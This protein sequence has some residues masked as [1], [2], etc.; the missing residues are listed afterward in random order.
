MA[1][2]ATLA[3]R[4]TTQ[5]LLGNLGSLRQHRP[6]GGSHGLPLPY[7]TSG[8]MP[9]P[10]LALQGEERRI[11]P[12]G[13]Q[14]GEAGW[15]VQ[16]Q[17]R[18]VGSSP[19]PVLTESLPMDSVTTVQVVTD[20]LGGFDTDTL[21]N[22]TAEIARLRESLA[23]AEERRRLEAVLFEERARRVEAEL[24]HCRAEGVLFS[25]LCEERDSLVGTLRAELMEA[26]GERDA[27]QAELAEA[28]FELDRRFSAAAGGHA[29]YHSRALRQSSGPPPSSLPERGMLETSGP[30]RLGS[31]PDRLGD[32][33]GGPWPPVA[34]AASVALAAAVAQAA[35][36]DN[37]ATDASSRSIASA[38]GAAPRASSLLPGSPSRQANASNIVGA[39][40]PVRQRSGDTGIPSLGQ[41]SGVFQPKHLG[42]RTSS[43][44]P[45]G[46]GMNNEGGNRSGSHAAR[47]GGI[48]EAGRDGQEETSG[49]QPSSGYATGS[50]VMRT[51]SKSGSK[52]RRSK[53]PEKPVE[54]CISV[55]RALTPDELR[56]M[57]EIQEPQQMAAVPPARSL[58][59]LPQTSQSSV[60]T[61]P[62]QAMV[63]RQASAPYGPAQAPA[64]PGATDQ[65]PSDPRWTGP[66][67]APPPPVRIVAAQQGAPGVGPKGSGSATVPT[68]S[69]LSLAD[70]P[71]P[72]AIIAT[73]ATN[74]PPSTSTVRPTIS[75][76][77]LGV[78]V[79]R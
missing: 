46:H 57:A 18:L 14:G 36:A 68:A 64:S 24:E 44:P 69:G 76:A 29:S 33:R 77:R 78:A 70:Q 59:S 52:G 54:I 26:Q 65:W 71:P 3:N 4:H 72:R 61:S 15:A 22:P 27:F 5:T 11:P 60:A 35:Q 39:M 10:P 30:T 37:V 47:V 41:H 49:Q 53:S 48:P 25:R 75:Q 31:G 50:A 45:A 9:S 7:G 8:A 67:A 51:P 66:G 74:S 1:A 28:R 16:L 32:G 73:A 34:T 42:P 62:K 2:P 19:A 63:S 55:P 21:A 6:S 20:S 38:R 79:R 58:R 43:L 40:G 17:A 13:G 23:R 12:G 56:E